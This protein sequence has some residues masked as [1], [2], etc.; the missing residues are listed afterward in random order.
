MLLRVHRLLRLLKWRSGG[1][2]GGRLRCCGSALPLG[3]HAGVLGTGL[4]DGLLRLMRGLLL[5]R[6]QLLLRQSRLRRL[7]RRLLQR[8]SLALWYWRLLQRLRRGLRRRCGQLRWL[9]WL[10]LRVRRRLLQLLQWRLRRVL[11]WL[12]AFG[13][14]GGKDLSP[15][16]SGLRRCCGARDTGCAL[17][18][19]GV[20]LAGATGPAGAAVRFLE[21]SLTAAAVAARCSGLRAAACSMVAVAAA[22]NSGPWPSTGMPGGRMGAG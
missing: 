16:G 17:T 12:L 6:R 2:R 4:G 11:R 1:G 15:F 14:G 5:L 22:A 9:H 18:G 7:L 19:T 8:H 21:A 20:L 10:R 13:C 3:L